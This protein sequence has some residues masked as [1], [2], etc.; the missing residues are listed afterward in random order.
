[1]SNNQRQ[2]LREVS[3]RNLGIHKHVGLNA[4]N[5]ATLLHTLTDSAKDPLERS[6]LDDQ[7]IA[8]ARERGARTAAELALWRLRDSSDPNHAA[9]YWNIQMSLLKHVTPSAGVESPEDM[10]VGEL[11]ERLQA[12]E[13][14]VV[15]L[16]KSS[17]ANGNGSE[18]DT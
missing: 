14:E 2:T 8:L 7:T 15:E 9:K 18:S 3:R 17:G 11:V 13:A 12:V 4:I 10:D 16:E 6:L 1:M 5:G